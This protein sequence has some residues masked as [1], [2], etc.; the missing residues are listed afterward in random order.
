MGTEKRERQKANRQLKY[1]QQVRDVQKRKL[2]RRFT[3]GAIAVVGGVL[4]ILLIGW[5]AN[6]SDD[7]G[8]VVSP[9]TAPTTVP[10]GET[11]VP[12]TFATVPTPELTGPAT[13]LEFTYGSGACPPAD[14]TEPVKTFTAAPQL[15]IDPAKTYSARFVTDRG[16]IVV[17]L[18][19]THSPGTVNNFVTLARSGYYDETTIFRT[20][21]SIDIIQG[22]GMSNTDDPG[23]SIPD[24]GTGY[25]YPPGV[26]A[27]ARSEAPNSA[28]GQW[29]LTTGPDSANLAEP[30]GAGTYVVFG[31][32]T[33]GSDVAAEINALA[34]SDGNTPTELVTL[35]TVEITES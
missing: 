29:F 16:D 25:Q 19:T 24:E 7:D 20:N 33:A 6:R 3:I 34:G 8:E 9:L 32:I 27:M 13:P 26:L 31:A 2:T 10:S 23:Y 5:L 17:E 12:P 22:G 30:S 11:S 28:G 35:Q 15:C 18:D 21:T 4:L 14:I 1:Q